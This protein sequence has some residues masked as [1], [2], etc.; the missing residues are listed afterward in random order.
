[1]ARNRKRDVSSTVA[2][3]VRG[4]WDFT[5]D[6][7]YYLSPLSSF[8]FNS[9]VV[10]SQLPSYEDDRMSAPDGRGRADRSTRR[11]S[12]R[13]KV[14]PVSR[15]AN[16]LIGDIQALT[17][18]APQFVIKCIRRKVR[19]EVIHALKKTRKGAGAGKP[20]RRNQSSNI[21]C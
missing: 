6:R 10:R 20:K 12:A 16:R 2:S 14:A 1:M 21:R 13:T 9:D 4:R 18:R 8:P 17:F 7:H 19:R 15:S 5:P 11:W 3:G